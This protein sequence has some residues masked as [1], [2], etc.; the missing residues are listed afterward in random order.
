MYMNNIC[1]VLYKI[2]EIFWSKMLSASWKTV[3]ALVSEKELFWQ[4]RLCLF[5]L[6]HRIVPP[7][8]STLQMWLR[9]RSIALLYR[10]QNRLRCSAHVAYFHSGHL[11]S[12]GI[13]KRLP[14]EDQAAQTAGGGPLLLCS[15]LCFLHLRLRVIALF[16]RA[17]TTFFLS[18]M[19]GILS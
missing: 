2:R 16:L 11:L 14:Y 18:S 6:R 10:Y 15:C 13:W 3:N 1:S 8:F 7:P 4:F 9:D 19:P 17:H 12:P 5:S